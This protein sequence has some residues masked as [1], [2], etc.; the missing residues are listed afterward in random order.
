MQRCRA[1]E[2][3]RHVKLQQETTGADL[4]QTWAET[5]TR[6]QS[7]TNMVNVMTFSEEGGCYRRHEF[8]QGLY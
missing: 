1:G 4:Q 8:R 3:A 7:G 2:V 5:Q 6:V